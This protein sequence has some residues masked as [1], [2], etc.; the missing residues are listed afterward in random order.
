[1]GSQCNS[2][3]IEIRMLINAIWDMNEMI[4]RESHDEEILDYAAN[5]RSAG[6][7]L[8]TLINSILDFSKIEDVK[9]EIIPVRY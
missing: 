3:K 5:I 9:M 7:T 1:M 2:I 4:L 6:K 8:L